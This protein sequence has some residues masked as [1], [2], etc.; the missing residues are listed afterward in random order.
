MS[1]TANAFAVI[2]YSAL[3]KK[4]KKKKG[5]QNFIFF[6]PYIFSLNYICFCLS[7]TIINSLNEES[8]QSMSLAFPL[9][10]LTCLKNAADLQRTMLSLMD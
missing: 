6:D 7:I 3:K 8:L 10:D 4:K 9:S 5:A 1:F 2:P